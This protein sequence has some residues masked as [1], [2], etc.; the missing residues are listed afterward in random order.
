MYEWHKHFRKGHTN[1]KED[2]Q[3]GHPSSSTT[4]GN[5]E[6]IQKIMHADT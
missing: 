6:H 1:I 2:P 4:D 3:T 5:V